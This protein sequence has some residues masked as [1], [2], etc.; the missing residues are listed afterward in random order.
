MDLSRGLGD[1]YKRQAKNIPIIE[2]NDSARPP[3]SS[4]IVRKLTTF[5]KIT[6][7]CWNKINNDVKIG[8][9]FSVVSGHICGVD[10]LEFTKFTIQVFPK[11][12]V[13][14]EHCIFDQLASN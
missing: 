6:F 7:F 3:T 12:K 9:V 14:I 8:I 5:L 1:V 10:Y 2:N 4:N 11:L 13:P